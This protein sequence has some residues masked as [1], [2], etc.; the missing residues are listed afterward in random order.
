M[1]EM[2]KKKTEEIEGYQKWLEHEIGVEVDS[3]TNKTV[4]KEYHEHD[5]N[6]PLEVIKRNRNKI[7]G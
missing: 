4:L 5:F 6:Q 1:I 3:L 7:H 2:N